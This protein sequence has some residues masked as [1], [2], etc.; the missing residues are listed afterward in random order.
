[1]DA[2]VQLARLG[3]ALP[4]GNTSVQNAALRK[5]DELLTAEK[6]PGILPLMVIQQ[7]I[8]LRV[9]AI[10]TRKGFRL[11][12]GKLK[13]LSS[14]SVTR[15]AR[16]S[17]DQHEEGG[18]KRLPGGGQVGDLV[19]S[20]PHSVMLAES[21]N[22]ALAAKTAWVQL[23]TDEENVTEI[24]ARGPPRCRRIALPERGWKAR[25]VTAMDT[26][27]VARGHF[28][29]D[30]FWPLVEAEPIFCLTSDQE[31][32]RIS[33]MR[34]FDAD[35][36]CSTDLSAATDH[37]PFITA[38]AVWM[39]I[40]R[41][42]MDAGK[43]DGVIAGQILE[44]VLG[45]HLG[46]HSYDVPEVDSKGNTTGKTNERVTKQGWLMGHPLTWIT[47]S[48]L[49]FGVVAS[50]VGTGATVIKGDDALVV[51][52]PDL[53]D[54][55]L[56]MLH[57]VGMVVNRSKTF[58]S[59]T[60]GIFCERSY[61]LV[62]GR[63]QP[64]RDVPLKGIVT[65]CSENMRTLGRELER[66]GSKTRSKLV[67]MIW[68]NAGRSGLLGKAQKLGI[69]LALPQE[70]GGLGI[71]HRNRLPGALRSSR[72][73]ASRLLTRVDVPAFWASEAGYS[74]W[75][76]T[77]DGLRGFTRDLH[78]QGALGSSVVL[79]QRELASYTSAVQ[80]GLCIKAGGAIDVR[81][82]TLSHVA[83]RLRIWR[84]K[85]RGQVP[86]HQINPAKWS[87]ARMDGHLAAMA[88]SGMYR[89]YWVELTTNWGITLDQMAFADL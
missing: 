75:Q 31:E 89:S 40:L 41:G 18:G 16:V 69:P 19:D 34:A 37:A 68:R 32:E 82:A 57:R 88:V 44:E 77:T 30:V 22:P 20:V 38:R 79:Q 45:L 53:I 28:L 70:L 55:Y 33:Q 78:R 63:F 12:R 59:R 60:L 7:H 35:R 6:H 83:R 67:R 36:I 3:R 26:R 66:L 10:A 42:L 46:P 50:T 43:L 52:T 54:E 11:G 56:T 81:P 80:L 15:T 1:V 21:G 73:Q 48:W 84:S 47:L 24:L 58:I 87:Y 4:V 14:A 61:R 39:G 29:R 27:E 51:S 65:P 62:Q 9:A 85:V 49:H 76:L 5:H 2:L 13:P 64:I 25:V 72:P 71:P 17:K 86:P 8:R 23:V 74:A